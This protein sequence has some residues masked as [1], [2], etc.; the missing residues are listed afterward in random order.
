MF[1][2]PVIFKFLYFHLSAFFFF[3]FFFCLFSIRIYFPVKNIAENFLGLK[4]EK[5]G[6]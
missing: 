2:L 1:N 3:F 4:K 6:M 5:E